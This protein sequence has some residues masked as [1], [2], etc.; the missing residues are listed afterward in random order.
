MAA[1]KKNQDSYNSNPLL[2]KV[3]IDI[4]FSA[5]NVEEYLKCKKSPVYFANN[6]I[7]VISLDAGLQNISLYKYQ[8]KLLK[9]FESNR[10][11]IVKFPRFFP[12]VLV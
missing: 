12:L 6:Y 11:V 1:K 8:E 2:K 7:K 4:Q 9:T 5:E 10:F 3:G